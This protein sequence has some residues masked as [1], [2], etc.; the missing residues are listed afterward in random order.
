VR[1]SIN[2]IPHTAKHT[3]LGA[4]QPGR[5]VNLEIDLIARYI[6]RMVASRT[7]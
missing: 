1:F 2:L 5:E 3:T 7:G 6:E 4:L